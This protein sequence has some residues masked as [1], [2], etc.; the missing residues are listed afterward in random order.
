MES[1]M[2]VEQLG[3]FHHRAMNDRIGDGG[4]EKGG[5]KRRG[6]LIETL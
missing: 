6:E 2:G 5:L 3:D 1:L 4:A